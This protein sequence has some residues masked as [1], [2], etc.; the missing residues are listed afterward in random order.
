[1]TVLELRSVS[2]LFPQAQALDQVDL[3]VRPGQVHALL[4]ENGA[5]KTTAIRLLAGLDRPDSGCVHL[6]GRPIRFTSRTDALRHGIG[7]VPQAESLVGELTLVENLALAQPYRV[8][9]RRAADQRLRQAAATAGIAV[10]LGVRTRELSRGQRQLAE[11]V[12]A[13]AQDARVLLLD[14]PTA[15]LGPLETSDL[16]AR[17]HALAAS[18]VAILL[19]THRLAEVRAVAG[20]VTV[21][22]HGRV[23]WTGASADID[24]AALVRTMVG[25]PPDIPPCE[26]RTSI[27]A[28]ALRLDAVSANCGDQ[29]PIRDVTLDV[30]A[31]EVVAVLGVAG[32]GQRALAE[33]VAGRIRPASGTRIVTGSVA[34]VPETRMEGLLPDRTA[35][36]SAVVSRLREP[37]FTRR[38]VVDRDAVTQFAADLLARHDVRPPDPKL[39]V[40]AL[41]GGN[42]QKLLVGRELDNGPAV[43]VLHGPT[44]GLDIRSAQG[45]QGE[46][47][48]T[49]AA[50]TAILLVSADPSEV[51]AV[52]DRVVVLSGGRI[53]GE[54][55]ATAFDDALVR[56][57]T[58]PSESGGG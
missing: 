28:P 56:R 27:G 49:A 11:L 42:Q 5:G 2:R 52:A 1:M 16:F 57:L 36:W 21:L 45:I 3:V 38:G 54:F 7:L 41:S 53:V 14:E 47:T 51:R 6:A 17:L 39:P 29:V 32:N 25:D 18:G 34:Y 58:A 20:T 35:R 30:H 33:V 44:Q 50:G 55:P 10:D 9:R 4:G 26:P 8:I 12:L 23:T 31:S 37:R 24:D 48:R 15:A 19:I 40:S 43:A 13:L 22:A 46:I